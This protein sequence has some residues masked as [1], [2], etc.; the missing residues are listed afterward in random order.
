MMSLNEME[1]AVFF[2][3]RVVARGTEEDLLL[4][5][6]D[7]MEKEIASCKKKTK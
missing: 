5:L 3:K 2:L 4:N 7:K 6:I 1:V